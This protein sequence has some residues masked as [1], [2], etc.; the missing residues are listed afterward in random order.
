MPIRSYLLWS[1]MLKAAEL[2]AQDIPLTTVAAIIGF[3][4]SAHLTR[5]FQAQFSLA[6]SFL[7][8]RQRVQV[9]T[10]MTCDRTESCCTDPAVSNGPNQVS[11]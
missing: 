5:V 10:C 2:F 9:T 1:K 6:P 8:N 11:L 3:S 4:D 7:V